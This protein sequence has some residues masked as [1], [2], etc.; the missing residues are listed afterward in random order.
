[1]KLDELLQR[2]ADARDLTVSHREREILCDISYLVIIRLRH[3]LSD[4]IRELE[5]AGYYFDHPSLVA[6]RKLLE[7]VKEKT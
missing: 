4:S 6:K 7:E 1:M 2:L 3:A 5:F